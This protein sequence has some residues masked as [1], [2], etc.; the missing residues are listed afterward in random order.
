MV[1]WNP[2]LKS[3]GEVK[4]IQNTLHISEMKVME[5]SQQRCFIA[6]LDASIRDR[7]QSDRPSISPFMAFLFLIPLLCTLRAKSFTFSIF[8]WENIFTALGPNLF[9]QLILMSFIFS[10]LF[11]S[12]SHD[13]G[14][15]YGK[16]LLRSKQ[17]IFSFLPE[18]MSWLLFPFYVCSVLN[19][20]KVKLTFNCFW[21]E[22]VLDCQVFKWFI[23]SKILVVA[24]V[25]FLALVDDGE[26]VRGENLLPHTRS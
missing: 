25:T 17:N 21:N 6:S 11:P 1:S 24:A 26:K 5:N 7:L 9:H 4:D 13:V 18:M 8:A 3:D 19:H 22:R 14:G 15:G 12:G 20:K 23:S 2:F 16:N 10:D